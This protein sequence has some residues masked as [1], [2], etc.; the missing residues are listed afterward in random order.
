MVNVK[1]SPPYIMN[2]TH[3][4][5]DF[6]IIWVY[7]GQEIFKR[8]G[9][10]FITES[11]WIFVRTLS[12]HQIEECNSR[13][14]EIMEKET[15]DSPNKALMR[16]QT[17]GK[18]AI[19]SPNDHTKIRKYTAEKGPVATMRK[20]TTKL[21]GLKGILKLVFNIYFFNSWRRLFLF[22]L[23]VKTIQKYFACPYNP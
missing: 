12:P 23:I 7:V 9:R 20:F 10:I 22:N 3:V 1:I 13:V 11:K 4:H 21:S 19:Y 17:W 16:T 6:F 14:S 5:F 8:E 18:Y 15:N 2:S